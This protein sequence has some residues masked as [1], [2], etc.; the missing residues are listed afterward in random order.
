P[1]L[2]SSPTRR[3]SDLFAAAPQAAAPQA[4]A[5]HAAAPHAA[6]PFAAAPQATPAPAP[7]R[8]AP[9]AGTASSGFSHP[10]A[11]VRHSYP[12]VPSG[13]G[14]GAAAG[15][16]MK[17]APFLGVRLGI[18]FGMSVLAL[19][20]WLVVLVGFVMLA[21]V[22]VIGAWGWLILAGLVASGIWRA[23]I[24]YFLYLLKAAH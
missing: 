15:L 10:Q 3:S 24:R 18:L 7:A 22:S 8:S 11:P 9:N 4:A 14:V 13:F 23:A 16:L 1:P 20:F 5:P 12:L 19:M 17:T 6:A 21:K 2:P